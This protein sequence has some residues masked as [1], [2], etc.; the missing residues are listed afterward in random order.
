MVGVARAAA[1]RRVILGVERTIGAPLGWGRCIGRH[2]DLEAPATSGRSIPASLLPTSSS[3]Q[4]AVPRAATRGDDGA[5]S[6]G[7]PTQA[8][9]RG[10]GDGTTTRRPA[11]LGDC[12][13]AALNSWTAAVGTDRRRPRATR[14]PRPQPDEH[15]HDDGRRDR[16]LAPGRARGRIPV[17]SPRWTAVGGGGRCVDRVADRTRQKRGP[18]TPRLTPEAPPLR[19]APAPLRGSSRGEQGRRRGSRPGAVP[20]S[21]RHRGAC[22]GRSIAS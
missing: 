2:A 19:P 10:E 1:G 8:Q 22:S 3:Q 9:N 11:V 5:R 4:R 16:W 15:R 7:R 18:P 20:A 21:R 12:H 13:R 6:V 14:H 17:R